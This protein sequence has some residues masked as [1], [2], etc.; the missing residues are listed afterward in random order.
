M[1]EEVN[2]I[3][4]CTVR[5]TCDQGKDLMMLDAIPIHLGN[6]YRCCVDAGANVSR[7]FPG[8]YSKGIM[9]VPLQ[10]QWEWSLGDN[11]MVIHVIPDRLRTTK[12]KCG[13]YSHAKITVVSLL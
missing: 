1:S 11:N 7:C 10:T 6:A 5:G 13:H 2:I 4:S 3:L 8:L 12:V 9:Y